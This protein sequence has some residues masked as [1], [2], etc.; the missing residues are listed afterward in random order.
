MSL[1]VGENHQT[2]TTNADWILRD[3]NNSGHLRT[4]KSPQC[5]AIF[6]GAIAFAEDP[7]RDVAFWC[8]GFAFDHSR[9]R[10]VGLTQREGTQDSQRRGSQG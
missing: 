1:V 2:R 7:P 6:R 3:K 8:S 10:E 5:G 4:L 9:A